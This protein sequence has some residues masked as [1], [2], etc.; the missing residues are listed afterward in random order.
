MFSISPTDKN[1]FDF[2]KD[3]ELNSYVN[4]WTPTP[5]N[6]RNLS[7]GNRFY[8]MLKSPIRKLGGFGEFQ[9]YKNLTAL[10]AWNE[11]GFR[12]GRGSKQEFI[13]SIQQYIDKNSSRLGGQ[14]IDINTYEIGCISLKNCE[15]WETEKFINIEDYDVTFPVQ[16]VKIKY[17]TTYDPFY[18]LQENS[19]DFCIIGAPRNDKQNISINSRYG[20]AE[21]RGKVL[22]AYDNQCCISGE[23]IPEILEAAHIQ[24]YRNIN[25][26]HVQNGLLLRTDLHRLYDNGLIYIDENYVINISNQ[27]SS[28]HYIQYHDKLIKLPS[29]LHEYPSKDALAKRKELFRN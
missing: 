28:P 2:L 12:N 5:W 11:F 1:W 22:R 18:N 21:F 6:V 16:V 25:S 8:F 24:E 20:Q 14:E 3:S 23:T 13:D 10:Q 7:L 15:F 27:I 17:F 29:N 26:N 19:S 9:E 4:F